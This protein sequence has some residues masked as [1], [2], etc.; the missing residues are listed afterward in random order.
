MASLQFLHSLHA[1]AVM[2]RA[3]YNRNQTVGWRD[4][5]PATSQI[6]VGAMVWDLSKERYYCKTNFKASDFSRL[7]LTKM[8]FALERILNNV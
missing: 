1:S 7:R 4:F 2:N 5:F 6:L 8:G 3:L